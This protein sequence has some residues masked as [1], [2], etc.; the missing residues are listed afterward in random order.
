MFEGRV[1]EGEAFNPAMEYD[2]EMSMFFP[3]SATFGTP[4]ALFNFFYLSFNSFY[5]NLFF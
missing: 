4:A 5:V 1:L 2:E 3:S